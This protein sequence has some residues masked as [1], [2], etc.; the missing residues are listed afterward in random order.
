MSGFEPTGIAG[1]DEVGRGP[2]AGPV[3]AATVILNPRNPIADLADSK[4]LSAKKRTRLAREIKLKALA[5]AI[6]RAEVAEIDRINILQASLLAMRRAVL[7]LPSPP[8]KVLVDGNRCP[9]LPYRVEAIVGGDASVQAISAAS[10]LAKVTRDEEMLTHDR[11]YPQY[12]F[13]RHK[14]YATREHLACLRKFGASPIH[15]R[16]FRPVWEL[17][18]GIQTELPFAE[19]ERR[20]ERNGDKLRS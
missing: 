4:A 18:G 12:K 7:A 11:S 5:W 6:G 13:A 1:V 10:I 20:G 19:V 16:T 2:L 3:L 8:S 14:G 17:V 15:R 9:D